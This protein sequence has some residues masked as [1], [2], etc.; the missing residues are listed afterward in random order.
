MAWKIFPTDFGKA[1]IRLTIQRMLN[2]TGD[3]LERVVTRN[4]VVK[5]SCGDFV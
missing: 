2:A 4:N 1:V 3:D 5:C